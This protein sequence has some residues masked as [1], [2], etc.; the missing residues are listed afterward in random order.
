[1]I[2][3]RLHHVSIIVPDDERVH[4]LAAL[5][6]LKLGRR[7]F[8]A[9]YE[10]DCIFT[11]G[12]SG[13]IEFIIAKSGKLS[14]FNKGMGGLHHIAIAVP[15][16]EVTK[17]QLAEQG[18]PLLETKPVDAGPIY[19]NFLAPAYTRG[20]IVEYVQEVAAQDAAVDG[21]RPLAA[22]P[23]A[24][25][26]TGSDGGRLSERDIFKN[27]RSLRSEGRAEEA[28]LS[29]REAL[30]RNWLSPE[31]I[32]KA[33]RHIAGFLDES[34]G[35]PLDV[36]VLGQCTTHWV[37]NCLTAVGWGCGA[38]VRTVDGQYDNV[39]QELMNAA[40]SGRRYE[41]VVLVPWSER[42]LGGEP[43]EGA[44]RAAEE[45]AFWQ[46]AWQI[47]T[48]QMSSRLIQVGY[49][50]VSPGAMGHHL[51]ARRQGPVQIVRQMNESLQAALPPSAFFVDLDQASGVMGRDQFYD[52]RRYAWTKQPFSEAGAVRLAQHLW[53]GIRAMINGPKKVLVLDLDNTLWGGVVGETGPLGIEVGDGASGESFKAFQ[54]YAK[55]LSQRGVLLA[56]SSKNN[57]A[58]AR[59][60]F[61]KNPALPLKLSDFA[62]FEANWEPKSAAIARMAKTLQLGLDSFVFFD[63]NPAEREH[64]R[65]MLP[66]VE[67]VDVPEEPAQYIRALE[68]GQWFEA[69]DLTAEDAERT[70]QYRAEAERRGLQ[71]SFASMDDYLRSLDMRGAVREVDEADLPRVVQLLG[72]TNQFNLTTRR[73]SLEEVRALLARPRSIGLTVRIADR[74]ADYGLVAVILGVEQEGETAPTLRVDTWLMSCRVIART[75]EEFCLNALLHA[76]RERGFERVVGHYLPTKKNQLVA[77]LY[78]RLGFGRTGEVADNGVGYALDDIAQVSATTFVA[79]QG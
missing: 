70:A 25:L 38:A 23:Q 9:Q 14:K 74:F 49:D 6:G 22:E 42:L 11:T 31:G 69:L 51:S 7:Q 55:A 47:V 45:L 57:P 35:K 19:I 3:G 37:S 40:A 1:M 46:R 2:E 33:G 44:A 30:R 18:I 58:D 43:G 67:V 28:A 78:D 71:E 16:L 75:V 64:V 27:A 20:V 13:V 26:T 61:E 79:R 48:T 56:V 21:A 15:D 53:S 65:Q 12:S 54:Q 5:L 36:L 77:D 68:A 8:V 50:W 52:A 24:A 59:E 17:Q 39:I 73:H 10:A 63:D 29:L 41:A 76:A 4:E 34:S 66:E 32:E 72:K 62:A 60:P